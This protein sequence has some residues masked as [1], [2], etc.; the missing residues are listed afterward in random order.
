[1]RGTLGMDFQF[2]DTEG[3]PSHV[4]GGFK[5]LHVLDEPETYNDSTSI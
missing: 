3:D 1:M 5:V 4:Y 2:A